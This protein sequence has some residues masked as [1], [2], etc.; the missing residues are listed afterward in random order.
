[1]LK[2]K[3]FAV[4]SQVEKPSRYIGNEWNIIRKNWDDVAVRMVFSYPD[5]YEIGMSHL[6]L[7]ILY[8]LVNSRED[9]LVE[10]VFAPWIDMEEKMRRLGIPLFSLESFR[11]VKD[12]DVVG[13]TLQYELNFTNILN[14]L[15]LAG[16]PLKSSERGDNDPLVIAGGPCA[17]NP[18]PLSQFFDFFLIGDGE[19]ALLEV[20]D[21]VKESKDYSDGKFDREQLLRKAAEVEG[22]YVPR[23]YS[24]EYNPDGTVKYFSSKISLKKITKRV[25]KNFDEVYF[26][27]RPLVSITEIVHDRMMLEVARGCGRGCRFCQAGIIYRPVREK[28]KN[29]LLKQA[30]EM[31]QSTGHG[32]I[33]L[34]SLNTADYSSINSLAQELAE[35][36]ESKRISIS[37]PSL[38]VD[39][40][41]VDLARAVQRVR[42][43]TLTF[44]PEAGTQ[45]LR[46]VI[47]K[48]VSEEDLWEAVAAAFEAGWDRIKLYFMIGLPTETEED[49][50]GI[51]RLSRRVLEL[52]RKI[53]GKN[54]GRVKVTVSVSSF[55]PK[56]HTPFQ[57]AAQDKMEIL[58][59]KQDYL[60]KRLLGKGLIFNWHDAEQSFIEA[61]LA[62]GNRETGDV[63]LSAWLKGC[64]F[65]SWAESFDFSKWM[66]AFKEQ[67]YDPFSRVNFPW[68]TDA[69][70]PWDH[71]DTGVSKNFL[72]REYKRALEGIPSEGCIKGRCTGCGLCPTLK[73]YPEIKGGG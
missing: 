71:I 41:S 62:K 38:R 9:F 23:F 64:R 51:V 6:G 69:V 57:W 61:V 67:G 21:I 27:T 36:L 24:F 25:V 15:D 63:L 12:F 31:V 66:G 39:R 34:V 29:I 35:K 46:D 3:I 42:R 20:L 19:E 40:F 56:S 14:M 59:E 55:V 53:R 73:V 58:K 52:G 13:F 33:S 37:L 49:I 50:E 17:F 8:G 44:A 4:L 28:S 1:M 48:G 7:Q 45:R 16:I 54:A 43:A 5:I 26:P 60:K 30:E 11:P 47:N 68:E 65:D 22:V 10:R 72:I 18:E 32:E 2:E 70:L